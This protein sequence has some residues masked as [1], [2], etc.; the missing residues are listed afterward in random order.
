M[1]YLV[2][3][4]ILLSAAIMV[5]KFLNNE[6]M[7]TYLLYVWLIVD[8]ME[9]INFWFTKETNMGIYGLI[10]IIIVSICSIATAKRKKVENSIGF[11]ISRKF[12]FVIFFLFS[13]SAILMIYNFATLITLYGLDMVQIL[14]NKEILLQENIFSYFYMLGINVILFLPYVKLNKQKRI[15]ISIFVLLIYVLYP[16]RTNLIVSIFCLL[17]QMLREKDIGKRIKIKLYQVVIIGTVLVSLFHFS[18]I[19]LAKSVYNNWESTGEYNHVEA[20]ILD[21]T[22]YINGN[23]SNT[24]LYLEKSKIDGSEFVLNNTLYPLYIFLD[25]FMNFSKTPKINTYFIETGLFSTNTFNFVTLYIDD[26]GVMYAFICVYFIFVFFENVSTKKSV[27]TETIYPFILYC[28]IMSIRENDF[29]FIYFYLVNLVT[30]VSSFKMRGTV[31]AK[32]K[33]A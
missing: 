28:A 3:G 31:I 12:F 5:R 14:I 25:N 29:I 13:I 26:F 32:I 17:Y 9:I 20:A 4:G 11:T 18:Q 22:A 6:S 33:K 21:I 27:Y 24:D 7:V 19:A 15:A 23:I 10:T 8:I 1:I 16:K 2:L 30:Y